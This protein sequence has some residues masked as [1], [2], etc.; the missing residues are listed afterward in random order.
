M[1]LV[2]R[3]RCQTPEPIHKGS[4]ARATRYKYPIIT[5]SFKWM[6]LKRPRKEKGLL[7]YHPRDYF[8]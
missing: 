5:P 1:S 2:E 7:S 4:Q 3:G 8:A 6:T